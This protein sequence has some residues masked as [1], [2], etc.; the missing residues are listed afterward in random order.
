MAQLELDGSVY[1]LDSS[2]PTKLPFKS[3]TLYLGGGLSKGYFRSP[4]PLSEG[5]SPQEGALLSALTAWTASIVGWLQGGRPAVSPAH[6]RRPRFLPVLPGPALAGIL[7][8]IPTWTGMLMVW[9]PHTP[10]GTKMQR[11]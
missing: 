9:T 1:V 5:R 7:G 8:L 11:S 3:M 4:K 2:H 10:S 6:H